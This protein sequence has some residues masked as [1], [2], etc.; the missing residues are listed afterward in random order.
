L[1][2]PND[3]FT[4]V[5][6]RDPIT[7]VV[8]HYKMLLEFKVMNSFFCNDQIAVYKEINIGYAIDIE[9]G[10]KV[11]NLQNSVFKSISELDKELY[12]KIELYVDNKLKVDEV[13]GSTFTITDLSFEKI[14][15]FYPLVNDFQS[16]VLGVG[17]KN[18]NGKA[19]FSLS[20]DHRVIAGKDAAKF[21]NA[22][23]SRIE[24]YSSEDMQDYH[25]KSIKCGRCLKTIEEDKKIGGPGFLQITDHS[26]NVNYMCR[27][28]YEGF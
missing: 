8:S 3:T 24:A 4:L 25:S 19:L 15:D 14:E 12:D 27:I 18:E 6:I 2:L 7:R 17:S 23:K 1:K 21:L 22:L 9:N 20:F 5:C 16:C 28:C 13:T 10:L 11:I 26:G